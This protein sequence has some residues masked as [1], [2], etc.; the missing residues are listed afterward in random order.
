MFL[1]RMAVI[2]WFFVMRID[3]TLGATD[4]R[5]LG[6]ESRDAFEF[7]HV[8]RSVT[9]SLYMTKMNQEGMQCRRT[10]FCCCL[11]L[12]QRCELDQMLPVCPYC[13]A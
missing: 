7:D 2:T 12:D 9:V 5:G 4:T 10:H 13:S 8:N 1:Y 6:R 3:E 11:R